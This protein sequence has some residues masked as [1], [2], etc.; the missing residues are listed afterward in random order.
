MPTRS[1]GDVGVVAG[2]AMVIGNCEYGGGVASPAALCPMAEGPVPALGGAMDGRESS[3]SSAA[4]GCGGCQTP[5]QL[6]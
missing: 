4:C 3:P 2:S 6:R 1:R 5:E